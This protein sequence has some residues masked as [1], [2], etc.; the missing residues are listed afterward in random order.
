M[1]LT[2][3]PR[4][5]FSWIL[6][7][8][9]FFG[10]VPAMAGE[11][12][13]AGGPCELLI[14]YRVKPENR[15]AFR[16]FLLRE[17]TARLENLR[18][19]GILRS[20]QILFN[21]FV[22]A[23]T[24]DAMA[25]LSFQRYTDTRRWKEIERTAPGGLSPT[26][27]RLATSIDTVSADLSWEGAAPGADTE[28]NSVFYVIPYEYNA[29]DQYKKYVDDYVIPQTEGWLKEGVLSSYR[30]YMNRYP[31]GPAWDS[32][33]VFQY[34]DL[35]AFGRREQIVAKVRETLRADPAWK[36]LN[37]VKQT[38]RTE[39]ENTIAERLTGQ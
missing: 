9:M 8:G 7:A 4:R 36:A 39:S 23:R 20:Y 30:I 33:F 16:R 5:L 24:W 31:V 34:R 19:D 2:G 13:V 14:S 11:I 37:D 12:P 22:T 10:I 6:T 29:T 21:P 27:L 17:E 1:P 32:L 35:E 3:R 15:P 26:G 25:V 28:K 18:R 38:I